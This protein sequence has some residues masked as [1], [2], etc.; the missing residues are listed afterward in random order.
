MT[1]KSG[2]NGKISGHIGVDEKERRR[3]YSLASKWDRLT[4]LLDQ[5][6]QLFSV[7]KRPFFAIRPKRNMKGRYSKNP[8]EITAP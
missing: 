4:K 1:F 8:A 5:C 2:P 7:K 6:D 3:N